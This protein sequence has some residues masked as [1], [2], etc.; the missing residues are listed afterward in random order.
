MNYIVIELQ[1]NGS[2]TANIV[3]QYD[4]LP[5]AEQKFYA[6]CSSAVVSEVPV[7]S[8]LIIDERGF[9]VKNESF[10]HTPAP[11]PEPE[12]ETGA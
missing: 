4:N 9:L 8:A 1:T 2:T 6:V 3:T 11:E 12:P 7:H 10:T 5:Q